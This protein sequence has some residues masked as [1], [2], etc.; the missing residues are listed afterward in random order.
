MLFA[1]KFGTLFVIDLLTNLPDGDVPMESQIS[2]PCK[3]ADWVVFSSSNYQ[4][5]TLIIYFHTF[6]V[7]VPSTDVQY[8][9]K[10]KKNGI[11]STGPLNV[12]FGDR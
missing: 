12:A 4:E 3:P 5:I 7:L 8:D 2:H 11:D 9:I 1:E 10:H 6:I